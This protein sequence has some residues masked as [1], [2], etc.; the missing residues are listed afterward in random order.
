MSDL[1]PCQ[2]LDQAEADRIFF[3]DKR[4]VTTAV[5]VCMGCPVRVECG[6]E[7]LKAEDGVLERYGVF[8]GLRAEDRTAMA[9][10]AQGR[11]S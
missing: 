9:R 8:G 5:R 3:D 2:A 11:L 1:L 7:A 10:R 4:S 6:L